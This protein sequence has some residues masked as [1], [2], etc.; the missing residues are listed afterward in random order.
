MAAKSLFPLML[1]IWIG[2]F[3]PGAYAAKAT[4][5]AESQ[6]ATQPSVEATVRQAARAGKL[7]FMLTEPEEVIALIG[8]PLKKESI[9]DGKMEGVILRYPKKIFAIFA[10]PKGSSEP[11]TLWAIKIGERDLDI[12]RIDQGGRIV[13][14]S[15]DDLGKLSN[16]FIG[17]RGAS[18]IRLDLRSQGELL[19]QM[20]FDSQTEWPP[21][22]KLPTGFDPARL[23]EEGKNPGLGVRKLHAQGIDGRGVGI[24][25]IDQPLVELHQEYKDRWGHYEVIDCERA[26]PQLHGPAV[27]SIAVGKSC[28]VAPKATLTYYAIPTWSKNWQDNKPYSDL[29][30]RILDENRRVK[31]GER[32]RVVSISQGQFP[33]WPNYDLWK[34]AVKRAEAEGVVVVLCGRELPYFYFLL[35][36]IEGRDPDDPKSYCLTKYGNANAELLVLAENRTTA[37]ERG[38]DVYTYWREGGMSWA[39]PYL[40][41]LAALAFQVNPDIAPAKII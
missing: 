11:F 29:L 41:G 7:A 39:A 15:E 36:R 31:P 9:V 2:P 20:I 23:L 40:G 32:V 21:A 4:S 5:Q 13:L 30:N 34:K 26:E 19:S 3:I 24:A 27:A 35:R 28:G 38:P 22:D 17:L 8:K 6:A 16:P 12:G 14:R 18:L 1:V 10:K 37:S 25:I 33:G